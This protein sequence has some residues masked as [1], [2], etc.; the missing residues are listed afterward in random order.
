MPN[1]RLS[2]AATPDRI[3]P[4]RGAP[5]VVELRGRSRLLARVGCLVRLG[6]RRDRRC[7]IGNDV[8]PDANGVSPSPGS[9]TSG[10]VE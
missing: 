10:A 2:S 4:G 6:T 8:A 5:R 7:G 9:A 3:C 1:V